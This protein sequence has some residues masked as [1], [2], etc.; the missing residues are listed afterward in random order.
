M[1]KLIAIAA[2]L[3]VTSLAVVPTANAQTLTGSNAIVTSDHSMRAA[4]LIGLTVTDDHGEKLGK[5]VDVLVKGE[6]AEPTVILSTGKKMVAMPVSHL[7]VT[8][9]KVTMSDTTP[10]MIAAMAPYYFVAGGG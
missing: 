3:A 4:K 7:T 2:L 6:A 1:H 8:G 5:I 10:A 9:A